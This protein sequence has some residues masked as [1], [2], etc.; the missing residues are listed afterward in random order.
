MRSMTSAGLGGTQ[1]EVHT[2]DEYVHTDLAYLSLLERHRG[3][4]TLLAV[5]GV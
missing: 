1:V 3:G 5:L 4:Q 2:I